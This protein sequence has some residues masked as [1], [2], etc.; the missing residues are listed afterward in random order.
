[1]P[2][3]TSLFFTIWSCLSAGSDYSLSDTLSRI[4][5]CL[6]P[7]RLVHTLTCIFDDLVWPL[8][9]DKISECIRVRLRLLE[10][11]STFRLLTASLAE[12]SLA[13]FKLLYLSLV[14]LRHP[15]RGFSSRFHT[16]K[17]SP[18]SRESRVFD[19]AYVHWNTWLAQG[20]SPLLFLYIHQIMNK[21]QPQDHTPRNT[22]GH[23][24]DYDS[25]SG[26]TFL[27]SGRP[28]PLDEDKSHL[29]PDLARSRAAILARVTN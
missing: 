28:A 29:Y 11:Q 7:T 8:V 27:R 23:N 1:M 3:M 9:M 21:T 22:M 14:T 26:V 19:L 15:T 16:C 13:F 25:F 2:Y 12:R 5:F 10:L 24:L 18:P 20:V 17:S 4:F 6:F